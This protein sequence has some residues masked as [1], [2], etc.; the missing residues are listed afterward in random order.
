MELRAARRCAVLKEA[1]RSRLNHR[2]CSSA[3]RKNLPAP[4]TRAVASQ[5]CAGHCDNVTHEGLH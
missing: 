1:L 5:L 4:H 3:L 2:C